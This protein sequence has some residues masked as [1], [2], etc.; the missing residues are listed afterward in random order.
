MAVTMNYYQILGLDNSRNGKPL[1]AS[2]VRQAYKQALLYHHPD[3]QAGGTARASIGSQVPSIDDITKAY[4]V[5]S[6][7]ASR[8]EY[9]RELRLQRPEDDEMGKLN[10]RH[11]GMETVDLEELDFD[12]DS[13]C[14]TRPCR[15][16]NQPAFVISEAELEKNADYGEL[17][18]GCK[19]CSLWLKVLFSVAD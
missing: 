12:E 3:K 18:T 7:P 14:W 15:C 11:T 16:G 5:L 10:T 2:E 19:G 4:K 6:D 1:P 17:V 8:S 13:E 9:D